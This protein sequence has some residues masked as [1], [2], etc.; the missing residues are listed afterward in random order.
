MLVTW[1]NYSFLKEQIIFCQQKTDDSKSSG[2]CITKYMYS[3]PLNCAENKLLII[4]IRG[5]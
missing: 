2:K 4:I 1:K 5:M 3:V